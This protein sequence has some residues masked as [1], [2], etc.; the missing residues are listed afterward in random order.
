VSIPPVGGQGVGA[1]VLGRTIDGDV[2]RSFQLDGVLGIADLPGVA[3][4]GKVRGELE[5]EFDAGEAQ[6][7][8]IADFGF[9]TG[10]VGHGIGWFEVVGG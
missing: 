5:V 3:A 9:D 6:G 7:I 4:A 2:I 10:E 1:V 8:E